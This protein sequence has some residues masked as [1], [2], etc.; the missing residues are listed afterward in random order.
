MILLPRLALWVLEDEQKRQD[1]NSLS[2]AH[3][4]GK[5]TSKTKLG[6]EVE[7]AHTHL[8]IRPQRAVQGG[9]GFDAGQ[10]LRTAKS[11]QRFEQ[12]GSC[13]HLGPIGV[14]LAA[15][16]RDIG[17]GNHAHSFPKSDTIRG[18]GTI[19]RLEMFKHA[20]EALAIDL[21]PASS[22]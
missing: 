17:A 14:G 12:P 22:D 13:D 6:E 8:L 7:P 16:G 4:I 10:R 20:A 21:D 2:E 11:F 18:G 19:D 3:V 5:A 1:L 9:A 15:V